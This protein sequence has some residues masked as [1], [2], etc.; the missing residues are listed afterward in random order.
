MN[1]SEYWLEAFAPIIGPMGRG[2]MLLFFYGVLWP[3]RLGMNT[4]YACVDWLS[5][6]P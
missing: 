2:F 1:N 6:P 5:G 3:I 4:Y